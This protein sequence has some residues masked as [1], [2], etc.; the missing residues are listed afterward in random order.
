M[1]ETDRLTDTQSQVESAAG[2]DWPAAV[3]PKRPTG[4]VEA[5]AGLSRAAQEA[6]PATLAENTKRVYRSAL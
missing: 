2:P 3:V 5:P 6:L 4:P 1:S